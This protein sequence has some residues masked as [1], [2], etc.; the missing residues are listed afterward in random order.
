[1]NWRPRCSNPPVTS[2]TPTAEVPQGAMAVGRRPEILSITT[3]M[4]PQVFFAPTSSFILLPA[5]FYIC[6]NHTINK[7]FVYVR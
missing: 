6:Y 1:M 7:E 3:S 4:K 2:V 5:V